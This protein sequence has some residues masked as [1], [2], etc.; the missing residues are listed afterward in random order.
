[1]MLCLFASCRI[2]FEVHGYHSEYAKLSDEDKEMIVFLS[3][4][5]KMNEACTDKSKVYGITARQ[6]QEFMAEHDSVLLYIWKPYCNGFNC[7]S[8]LGFR[9]YCIKNNYQAIV[10]VFCYNPF[11]VVR[12]SIGIDGLTFVSVNEKHYQTDK[13]SKLYTILN[14]ELS[15]PHIKAKERTIYKIYKKGVFDRCAGF[16]EVFEKSNSKIKVIK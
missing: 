10:L 12:S 6:L 9:D 14:Q 3:E 11:N 4:D 2:T 8:P 13:T 1:M 15:I 16:E 5:E 7:I